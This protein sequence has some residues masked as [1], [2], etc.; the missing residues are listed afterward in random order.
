MTTRLYT[1][2]LIGAL[3]LCS[4][5]R[6]FHCAYRNRELVAFPFV[7]TVGTYVLYTVQPVEALPI[8]FQGGAS[9]MIFISLSL[10]VCLVAILAFRLQCVILDA[11]FVYLSRLMS[12]SGCGIQFYYIPTKN[13][14]VC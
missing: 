2:V 14:S 6:I 13:T 3:L 12:L 8:S 4:D 10:F 5:W 9:V 7:V 1:S 11:V